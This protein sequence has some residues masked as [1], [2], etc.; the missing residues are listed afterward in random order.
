MANKLRWSRKVKGPLHA[1]SLYLYKY[2]NN[3]TETNIKLRL[4]IGLFD[5]PTERSKPLKASLKVRWVTHVTRSI[6][7]RASVPGVLLTRTSLSITCCTM[8]H[9]CSTNSELLLTK[10]KLLAKQSLYLIFITLVSR[11]AYGPANGEWLLSFLAISNFRATAK[12][13]TTL[14]YSL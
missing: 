2:Y 12:S 3:K 7:A 11:R 13:R 10:K 9:T 4:V 14:E 8:Q 1:L 6:R 5:Y